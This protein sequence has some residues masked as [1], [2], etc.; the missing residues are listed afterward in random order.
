[1]P[2]TYKFKRDVSRAD[3]AALPRDFSRGETVTRGS[4]PFGLCRD[5]ALYG[6]VETVPCTLDGSYVFTVP[7][8][9]L[10]EPDGEAIAGDYLVS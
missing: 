10:S 5:D 9:M 2:A 6:D 4:D 7:V 1:M 8:E 3:W